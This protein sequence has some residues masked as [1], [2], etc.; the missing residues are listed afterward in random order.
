MKANVA[1]RLPAVKAKVGL[2]KSSI[3]SLIQQNNFPAGFL[4]SKRARAWLESDIDTW[5]T[6]RSSQ[7]NV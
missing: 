5:I 3:Y 2:S 4:I 1:L 7:S 6:E